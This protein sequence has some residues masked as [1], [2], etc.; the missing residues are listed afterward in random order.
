MGL[1]NAYAAWQTGI[2]RF[3]ARWRALAAAP[4]RPAP[5]ATSPPKTW[6][7][8]CSAWALPRVDA[9]AAGAAPARARWLAGET[10]HGALWQAGLPRHAQPTL[11]AAAV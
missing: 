7:T 9:R 4:T 1:A 10:L 8:C 11:A 3:D 2:T 5:A 6:N